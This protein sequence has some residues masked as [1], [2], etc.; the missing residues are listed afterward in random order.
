[1]TGRARHERP[2][3]GARPATWVLA[4]T[5]MMT[6]PRFGAAQE[7]RGHVGA[8]GVT[9]SV[10]LTSSGRTLYGA[11]G[12]PLVGVTGAGSQALCQGFW[13]FGDSRVV[14]VEPP[15]D[16]PGLPRVLSLSAP[17]PNP[18]RHYVAFELALPREAAV[19]LTLYDVQGRRVYTMVDRRVEAGYHLL[20]W[21]GREGAGGDGSGLY[22]ARLRVDGKPVA[23]RRIVMIR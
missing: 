17:R 16:N 14:A 15:V 7:L 13:C 10:G 12:Q 19:D 9:A 4:L 18:A 23:Y 8:S 22:F 20:R 3:L 5:I 2:V 6:S 11:L 1:M 21:D